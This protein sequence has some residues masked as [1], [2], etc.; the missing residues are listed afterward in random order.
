MKIINK[1]VYI[2]DEAIVYSSGEYRVPKDLEAG[3]YYIW[4]QD[5]YYEYTRGEDNFSFESNY[6]GYAVFEKKDKIVFERGWMTPINN[7]GYINEN[8]VMLYPNHVYRT[9]AEIPVGFYLF[10][11]D[12]KYYIKEE[13]FLGEK[14]C[15]IDLYRA[16]SDSRRTRERGEYGCVEITNEKRHIVVLNGVAMYYG[17]TRFDELQMLKEADALYN[18]FYSM[19]KTIFSNEILEMQL[20]LKYRRGGRFCGEITMD[21]LEY[22]WYSINTKCKWM[23]KVSPHSGQTLKHMVIKFKTHDGKEEIC[24]FSGWKDIRYVYNDGTYKGY[25]IVQTELP[26]HFWGQE[27]QLTLCEYNDVKIEEMLEDYK[28]IANYMDESAIR[29]YYKEDFEQLESVLNE[30]RMNVEQELKC[31]DKMPDIIHIILPTLKEIAF[32]EQNF[33]DRTREGEKEITFVVKATYNKAFYCIAKLADKAKNVYTQKNGDEFVITFDAKQKECI[34]MVY[35]ILEHEQFGYIDEIIREFLQANCREYYII[36]KVNECIAMLNEMYGYS[37]LYRNSTLGRIIKK[38]N[39]KVKKEVDKIYSDIVR[40]NRVPTKWGNEYR[41]F[42]LISRYNANAQY[43]YH[44]DWLGQQ[45]LDIYISDSKIGIEYQ[46]EQHYKAVDIWGGEAALKENQARDL[47][48]KKLCAENGV[49]L[50]EWSYE[51]PVN[52]EHVVQFMKEN[53]IPFVE[54]VLD[55]QVRYEMAPVIEKNKKVANEKRKPKKKNIKY[56]IV[57]YDLEGIYVNKYEDI[58]SAAE[59][60]EVS[61]TS[62]SKVLRGER[63]SAAGFIWRKIDVSEEIAEQIEVDF[64]TEKTNPGRAKKIAQLSLEGQ[65]VQEFESVSDAA[66]KT[67]ISL[68]H[69]QNELSKEISS[70]WKIL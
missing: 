62:I 5:I 46:G 6:D 13:S 67:G 54:D 1:F 40:E 12:E 39:H 49:L 21:V 33:V 17:D 60:V 70:E 28:N 53:S 37:G 69:I 10:K 11:F 47:R 3:E 29:E 24:T 43:Q 14:E 19:G 56:Y 32:A 45:S 50:L 30:M 22:D 18:E 25:Y 57:Q 63:N 66:R 65:V 23:G 15:G 26:M 42:S 27:L 8:E 20:F 52:D 7:I 58:S 59:K 4:G 38:Q 61:N 55:V 31:F 64:D 35:Y 9:E 48:K 34:K 16:N 2:K 36:K 51:C 41:L 44:S 68:K